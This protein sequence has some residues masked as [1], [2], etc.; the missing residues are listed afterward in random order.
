[1]KYFPSSEQ[2]SL[3][4]VSIFGLT[5]VMRMGVFVTTRGEISGENILPVLVTLCCTPKFALPYSPGNCQVRSQN[6]PRVMQ[7]NY[8]LYS[9]NQ[10]LWSDQRKEVFKGPIKSHMLQNSPRGAQCKSLMNSQNQGF[11]SGQENEVSK[12]PIKSHMP[13]NMVKH[14]YIKFQ[15]IQHKIAQSK[16]Q[17]ALQ[18]TV[19]AKWSFDSQKFKFLVDISF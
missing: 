5:T 15:D 11:G 14:P 1:M 3:P 4:S 13:T 2:P 10:G 7:F 9:Q 19:G 17:I 16:T 8:L 6:S 12:G 18:S